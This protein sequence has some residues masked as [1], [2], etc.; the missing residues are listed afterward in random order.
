MSSLR[1]NSLDSV[2]IPFW[3]WQPFLDYT[4]QALSIF[5]L[6]PYPIKEEFLKKEGTFGP[7]SDPVN[8]ITRTWACET[9]KLR[10]VRA[11]CVEAGKFASV[12]NFV[13]NPFHTF[14]LP[15]FGADFVTLSSGHLIALD[16]QPALKNDKL[17]TE[18]VWEHLLP[19]H[20]R[21]Q[22]SL[23][24]GGSIPEEAKTYFSPG[25][26]WTRLPLGEEGDEIIDDIIKPAYKDYLEL[27]LE[28]VKEAEVI[29]DERASLLLEG[30]KNYMRYRSDKDPARGML[31]RFY[32]KVWTEAYIRQ[33]LFDL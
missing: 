23:P 9:S 19:I 1:V 28:L 27:Y 8:V 2:N 33:V 4:T 29:P 12:F 15:F 7:K 21:W 26:L 6:A 24:D 30:Q 22:D 32:G 5:S 3:R 11:A 20:K 17:H 10:Q 14:E 18:K 25:F 16:F 13:V 31:T